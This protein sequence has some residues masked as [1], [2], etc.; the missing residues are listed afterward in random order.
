MNEIRVENELQITVSRK[1]QQAE[2]EVVTNEQQHDTD[3]SA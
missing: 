1:G 2:K 3:P